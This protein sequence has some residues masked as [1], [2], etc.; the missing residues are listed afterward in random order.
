LSHDGKELRSNFSAL[1]KAVF[2]DRECDYPRTK[3]PVFSGT[4]ISVDELRKEGGSASAKRPAVM[5]QKTI[6]EPHFNAFQML[7]VDQVE[8]YIG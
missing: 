6:H 5:V 1:I 4:G 2:K 8:E 3:Y 7:D